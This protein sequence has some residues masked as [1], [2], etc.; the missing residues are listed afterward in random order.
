M[1]PIHS[2]IGQGMRNHFE[3]LVSWYEKNELFSSLSRKQYF[4]F[5]PE[6]RSEIYRDQQCERCSAVGK[7]GWQQ[8]ARK[9]NENSESRCSTNR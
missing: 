8:C 9:S 7:R 4:Q 5:L 1:I 6:P 2:E 3:K